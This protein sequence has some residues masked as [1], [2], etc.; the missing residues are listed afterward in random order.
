MYEEAVNV[1]LI[2]CLPG[3]ATRPA[4]DKSHLVSGLDILPTLCDYAGIPALPSFAGRSLRPLLEATADCLA[5]ASGRGAGEQSDSAHGAQRSVQVCRCMLRAREPEMLF[6][7]Q[8]DA[9]EMRNLAHG[10]VPPNRCW[11][12]HRK[13][14]KEWMARTKDRL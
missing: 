1:P 6:D 10:P 11:Q 12:S 5:A 13:L 7:L 2:V 4:V 8:A 3:K 9:G 14:L